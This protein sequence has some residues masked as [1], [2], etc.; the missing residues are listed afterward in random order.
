MDYEDFA[1]LCLDPVRLA[2]L[3]RAAEGS[4][5]AEG[6]VDGLDLTRRTALETIAG[7]RLA[8]VVDDDGRLVTDALHAIAATL[9]RAEPA[10]DAVLAG[11][12]TA[13]ESKVLNTFFSA[14]RLVEIPS[15]RRKRLVV[16]E[17]LAQDFE[18]G[19]RYDEAMV[20]RQLALY[21]EDYAALR[22]YLVDESLLSRSAGEYWRTGGRFEESGHSE[23]D[24]GRDLDDGDPRVERTPVLVTQHPD[25]RLVPYARWHRDG[26]LRATDDDRITRHMTDAFP[27]PYTADD[28][29]MWIAK[30][31]AQ[32][33]PLSFAIMVEG[34]VAGGVGC[35]PKADI[36]TGT[37]E[38]GWWLTPRYWGRGFAAIAVRRYIAYCFGDLGLHRVEAGVFVSNHASARVAE[39][40]GFR[41]EGVSRDAY[42]KNG[43]LVDRVAYGLARSE[44]LD[45]DDRG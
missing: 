6:L 38:V 23:A 29:A 18:P 24:A 7:L 31:E 15:Q 10:S 17:R 4:L 44:L 45:A 39:K 5:S 37:A 35:E 36:R 27:Y 9:P 13:A 41:L 43:V 28:A 14:D 3:G 22:R 40:A 25:V 2:G 19:V 32:D 8:G 12:W 30:C 16:L 42:L 20:S 11:D 33:P 21:N 1:R 34:E 26:I